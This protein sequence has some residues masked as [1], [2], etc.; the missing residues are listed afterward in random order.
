MKKTIRKATKLTAF[1]LTGVICLGSMLCMPSMTAK[2]EAVRGNHML[3]TGTETGSL[4][5]KKHGSSADSS[6]A[7]ASFSVYRV[8]ELTPAE[9]PGEYAA[10]KKADTFADTLSGVTADDLGNYS[11]V[12]IENLALDLKAVA[13]SADVQ[14]E[15]SG[16]TGEDGTCLFSELPLG[17]YLV[18][19]TQAPEGYVA[20][21]P[22]LI[23]I[24]STN[25]Y[26]SE[27]TL[28][29]VW[30]YDVE[31]EPKNAQVGIEKSLA[32]EE[33]GTAGY[34][35]Y[36]QYVVTTAI[37]D[38]PDEYFDKEVTFTI[39]D[40][41]SDGL[42]IQNS[43][44]Y[45]VT[46]EVGGTQVQESAFTY[47]VT[48]SLK[49]GEEADLSISFSKEFIQAHRAESVVVNYYAKV[50]ENA[51]MGKTGNNNSAFLEYNHKAGESTTSEGAGVN[52]YSFG[53]DVVKYTKDEGVKAL[54]NA[55]FELTYDPDGKSFVDSGIS[56]EEGRISFEAI[57]AGT[58][59]LTEIC[60]PEGYTLLANPIKV[61]LIADELGG[62]ATGTFSVKI[63]GKTITTK[64]GDY[65][66]KLDED[67]GIVTVAVENHK[68]FSLPST[69]GAGVV[70]FLV[71]G[72]AGVGV[73]TVAVSAKRR[74]Q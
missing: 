60:S 71:I 23:A 49:T 47:S 24:P 8:M 43:K 22:F 30:V 31:A 67:A 5:I 38:Y 58:Y 55:R 18:V 13:T 66:S 19:E 1:A 4:T 26:T 28:G 34:G 63:D 10:Y 59:Y 21:S 3:I 14:P 25:N 17:Y 36:V 11:S 53:I 2:A 72:L 62:K 42:D 65:V 69:G 37:P 68:G 57:G 27:D 74:K 29:Y 48:A 70:I 52:V 44:S 46:V 41:M 15:A 9:Q 39:C 73:L 35:E 16:V 56:D 50:T 6:L 45:P 12:E 7:G 40:V 54:P 64:T 61:E 20:G 32:E 51:V 33:D